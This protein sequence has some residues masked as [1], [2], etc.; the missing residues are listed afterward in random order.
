MNLRRLTYCL[1]NL[2]LTLFIGNID[3][4]AQRFSVESFRQLPNDVSAFINPVKDLNDES[5]GLIKVMAPED[6]VF[7][8]PLGIVKRTD[9]VGEIWLYV[10]KGTKKLTIK[11]PE[12]GVIRDY[13]LPEKID[14]HITYELRLSTPAV[15]VNAP[16]QEKII[17][18]VR[19]TLV[20]TRIDTLVIRPTKKNIPLD[21]SAFATIAYGGRAQTLSG[22]LMFV[23]MKRH[24]VF[25]HISSDFGSIGS[26]IGVC[27]KNGLM[28]NHLPYYSGHKRHSFLM[29]NIGAAHRLSDRVAI[30]EGL[31][32]SSTS[33]A[34]ELAQ[35]EGGGYV[36]NSH[37][38]L[39]GLSVEAGV[40]LKVNRLRI[41]VSAST[42]RAKEWYASAGIGWSFGK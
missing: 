28:G 32:Y 8:T 41:T 6:F 1:I 26:T 12:W 27:D 21:L 10:P 15:A 11:H 36:K 35:S 40:I 4:A 18:T 9:K 23:A 14:G 20:L 2:I 39:K 34:W 5:C 24:G 3:A 13:I 30:F 16:P 31:G 37:Y 29:A 7:S 38:C 17:T 22:G 19:D 33:L 25:A 42:I